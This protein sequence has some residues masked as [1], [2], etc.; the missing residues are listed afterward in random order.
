MEM[1]EIF[2]VNYVV[3]FQILYSQ[4]NYENFQ[5]VPRAVGTK[6]IKIFMFTRISIGWNRES[7]NLKN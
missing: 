4:L 2:S 7:E 3:K 6:K 1:V 5:I